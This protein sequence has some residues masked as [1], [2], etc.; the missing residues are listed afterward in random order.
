MADNR[1]KLFLLK[2]TL[3]LCRRLLSVFLNLMLSCQAL[4]KTT[5]LSKFLY[6]KNENSLSFSL[7]SG[8]PGAADLQTERTWRSKRLE[9]VREDGWSGREEKNEILRCTGSR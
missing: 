5:R 6:K 9:Q 7:L 3:N 2:T 1:T 4:S 8:Q